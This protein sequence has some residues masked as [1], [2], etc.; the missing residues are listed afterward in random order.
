MGVYAQ[1]VYSSCTATQWCKT[2]LKDIAGLALSDVG[3]QVH[4]DF[5]V[6][7]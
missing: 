6:L 3:G 1:L 7:L 2:D 5:T 4:H